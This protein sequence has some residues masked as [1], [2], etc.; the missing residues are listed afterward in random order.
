MN[1][2]TF[3]LLQAITC[4][5]TLRRLVMA[6]PRATLR[7]L[8]LRTMTNLRQL[9][10]RDQTVDYATLQL[11]SALRDIN[12]SQTGINGTNIPSQFSQSLPNLW[13]LVL[14]HNPLTGILGQ[15]YLG[16]QRNL[17]VLDLTKSALRNEDLE[18]WQL[19]QGNC[20]SHL[21]LGQNHLSRR[22]LAALLGK[23]LP[24]LRYL[25][26]RMG[27]ER[28]ASSLAQVL[29]KEGPVKKRWPKFERLAFNI[30][31]IR[32]V[33]VQHALQDF[34]A[35]EH[36]AMGPVDLGLLREQDVLPSELLEE[37]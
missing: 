25:D 16:N 19:P 31:W 4:A 24:E 5:P 28:D 29:M 10:L 7:H 9:E 35:A 20:I 13:R 21:A 37:P 17:R 8:D 11:P 30:N 15:L 33:K 12:L 34:L 36:I 32:S 1:A 22:A 23:P 14:H 26:I 2:A 27:S 3:A 18:A 6:G